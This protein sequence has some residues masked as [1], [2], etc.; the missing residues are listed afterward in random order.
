MSSIPG[1]ESGSSGGKLPDG[2]EGRSGKLK[3]EA[4][5]LAFG[6][7]GLA[8]GTPGP[9]FGA[10]GALGGSDGGDSFDRGAGF[11][12]SSFWSREKKVFSCFQRHR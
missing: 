3:P 7:L 5:G 12:L 9:P 11:G 10:L 1:F 6:T 4:L 2:T 8:F